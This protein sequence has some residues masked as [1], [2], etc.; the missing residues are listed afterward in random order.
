LSDGTL[1]HESLGVLNRFVPSL[2]YTCLTCYVNFH[3][4]V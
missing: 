2:L 4:L 1:R 3:A